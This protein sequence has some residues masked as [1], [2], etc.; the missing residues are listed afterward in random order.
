[1]IEGKFSLSGPFGVLLIILF[2][3]L[4]LMGAM[5]M[6]FRVTGEAERR[7]QPDHGERAPEEEFSPSWY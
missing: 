4:L 6:S 5:W 1:M 2:G 3:A 7:L